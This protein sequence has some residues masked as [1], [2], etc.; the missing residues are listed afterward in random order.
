MQC[1]TGARSA[2]AASVLR[3]K[4]LT[5]V[6]SLVGGFADWE[7]AGLPVVREEEGVGALTTAR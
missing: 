5:N 3:A 6:V 2:I 1:Q 7:R 4:G